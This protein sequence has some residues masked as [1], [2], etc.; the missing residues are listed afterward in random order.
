MLGLIPAHAGKTMGYSRVIVHSR[1]HPRSRG[2]NATSSA[3]SI[4][5]SGSSPLTRGKPPRNPRSDQPA[6]LIPAHAGKT[7]SM[8]A[9]G[10]GIGAHPRSR[11]ENDTHPLIVPIVAGSSP[12]TRGKPR[13]PMVA[14][15]PLR[16]IPAHAGKTCRPPPPSRSTRA[17]PRSRGENDGNVQVHPRPGGS[18]PL[19]RGKRCAMHPE[20][21]GNGLIPAHAGKTTSRTRPARPRGAH[22]R[23]RGE[24]GGDE[25]VHGVRSGSSP[26][27]RGKPEV[28]R[29]LR[30]GG[31]LIPAH[32]GK[33]RERRYPRRHRQAHPRSRGENLFDT[34]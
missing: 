15:R 30:G 34:P 5:F 19:T 7:L 26:L 33:T 22:P 23:S 8:G 10:A 25:G 1:A 29:G 32:A 14:A 27:T 11:G 31:G 21:N 6:R 3:A 28:E 18:S 9:G 24:N 2:E 16:L 20:T 12:L 13:D 4:T 17:H